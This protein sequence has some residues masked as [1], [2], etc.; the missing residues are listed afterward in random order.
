MYGSLLVTLCAFGLFG[1]S[2][3]PQPGK[4]PGRPPRQAEP[5]RR[6]QVGYYTCK[7]QEAAVKT[8]PAS[9]F[10]PKKAMSILSCGSWGA[11]TFN[12]IA[13]RQGSNLAASWSVTSDPASSAAS[14]CTRRINFLRP[15]PDRPL[16]FRP[17]PANSATGG[18]EIPLEAG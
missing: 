6:S 4:A 11:A 7:G 5:D 17:G 2:A 16:G 15:T 12:G 18:V 1:T 3:S 14:T 10:S 13:I 9:V 8:F